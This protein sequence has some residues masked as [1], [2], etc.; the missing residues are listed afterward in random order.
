MVTDTTISSWCRRKR[1]GDLPFPATIRNSGTTQTSDQ[2]A[3]ADNSEPGEH[4][5]EVVR[6]RSCPGPDAR[7]EAAV[8]AQVVR[9]L[10]R[11][12]DDRHVEE[13]EERDQRRI[14]QQEEAG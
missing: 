6:G 9:R 14:D 11:I 3:R 5:I 7:D 2:I 10:R 13:R 8:F 4:E 1:I 12:E